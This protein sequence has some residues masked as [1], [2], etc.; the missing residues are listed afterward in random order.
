MTWSFWYFC[1][2]KIDRYHIF[3]K[4][5]QNRKYQK[6]LIE[7]GNQKFGW[8]FY[9]VFV[10]V[11]AGITNGG[12]FDIFQIDS[13][14]RLWIVITNHVAISPSTNCAVLYKIKIPCHFCHSKI[15]SELFIF[16]LFYCV[17]WITTIR[18]VGVFGVFI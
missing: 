6:W 8:I 3:L 11:Y 16:A 2:V 18:H 4:N 15:F 7:D 12:C 1:P 9:I 13:R 10:C 5:S 17:V 14:S